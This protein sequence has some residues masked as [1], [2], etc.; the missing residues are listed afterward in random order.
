MN[1]HDGKKLVH[2]CR[3]ASA[4]ELSIHHI[5]AKVTNE[6]MIIAVAQM[7][8]VQKAE[9]RS[10][11]VPRLRALLAEAAGRKA[12]HVVFPELALTTFFPRWMIEDRA[13]LLAWYETEMPSDTVRPLFEDAQRLGVGFS[14]GYAEA[15]PGPDGEVRLFNTFIS[16]CIKAFQ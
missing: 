2:S 9:T 10:Q 3:R 7:G 14:L 5:T 8:P 13:E 16:R 15:A 12:E 1:V 6:Q 4:K 11:V